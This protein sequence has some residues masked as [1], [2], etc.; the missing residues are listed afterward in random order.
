MKDTQPVRVRFGVFELDLKS[1]ELRS[2]DQK[3]L[4]TEQPLQILRMLTE[5]EGELVAR[6]E[7]RKTFWPNDTIVEFDHSIN[8]AI[9]KLRKALGDS[10]E[11][12]R[13]IETMARR[14][15]RLLVRVE[16]VAAGDE[17]PANQ[18]SSGGQVS[19]SGEDAVA[20][21]PLSASGLI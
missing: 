1:G 8:A 7:I 18:E 9:G 21:L 10:A 19:G 17:G 6:E 4:L 13:Y 16:W 3:T 2:G 12:P 11:E 14:G 5:R 20:S 15:Y